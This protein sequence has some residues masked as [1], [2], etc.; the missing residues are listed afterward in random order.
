MKYI[1]TEDI[2]SPGK[3]SKNIDAFDFIFVLAYIGV[4]FVLMSMVHS[5]LRA[6]FMIFSGSIAIFLT[7][8]SPFNR[9]RRNYESIILM[10]K[11]DI[12]IYKAFYEKEI[13]K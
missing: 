7:C 10:L 12:S 5:H 3:V 9:R 8:R 4:S 6:I 1:V 2:E 11:R 13:D